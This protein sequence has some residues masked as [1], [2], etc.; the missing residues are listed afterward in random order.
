MTLADSVKDDLES[1]LSGLPPVDVLVNSAG[2]SHSASFLDTSPQTFE[3]S[4]TERKGVQ[5]G[6]EEVDTYDV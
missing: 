6:R 3:V 4:L 1:Q 5:G 2:V